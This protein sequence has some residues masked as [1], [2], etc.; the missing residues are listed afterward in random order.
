MWLANALT[1]SRIPLAVLF[2]VTY[3]DVYWSLG[4]VA[5]AAVT[6]ALDGTI[7]R[8]ARA[9]GSL[10][11]AGEWLD[12]AADKFFVVVVLATVAVREHTPWPIL[13]AIGARELLIVPLGITYRLALA[14]RP[15]VE[16]AFKA[17]A[18]GKATT[19]AQMFA[20]AALIAHLSWAPAIAIVTAVL[21][22]AAS[23]HYV[24]RGVLHAR[25][26]T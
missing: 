13:I 12:P 8:W 10:S 7:A 17:D 21:G 18:L 20:V 24:V 9:R 19:I 6:D 26:A 11:T 25:V 3:G 2:W 14:T 5:L 16:H 23:A 15:P 22:I 4:I 1:V